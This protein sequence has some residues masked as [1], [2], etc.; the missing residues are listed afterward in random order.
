MFTDKLTTD[1]LP[2]YYNLLITNYIE[3][4]KKWKYNGNGNAYILPS[5]YLPTYY[6]S[7]TELYIFVP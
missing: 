2:T 5:Y 4:E 3:K 1:L 7:G 6:R